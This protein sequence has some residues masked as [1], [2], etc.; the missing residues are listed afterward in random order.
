VLNLGPD[1]A[2]VHARIRLPACAGGPVTVECPDHGPMAWRELAWRCETCP[3]SVTE[4]DMARLARWLG[5][6]R[7]DAN[8]GRA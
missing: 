5:G 3:A 4:A 1:P 8:C 7:F 2:L 6:E